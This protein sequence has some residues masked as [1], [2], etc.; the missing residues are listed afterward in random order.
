MSDPSSPPSPSVR[1]RR[2]VELRTKKVPEETHPDSDDF[3]QIPSVR[4]V[5]AVVLLVWVRCG[6]QGVTHGGPA[7]RL[8][9]V[10][11][12]LV[13]FRD[14]RRVFSC[15]RVFRSFPYCPAVDAVEGLGD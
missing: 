7:V 3:G 11:K 15:T 6:R 12:R 13:V 9:E 10:A 5:L 4:I 2:K 1:P 14:R 8:N